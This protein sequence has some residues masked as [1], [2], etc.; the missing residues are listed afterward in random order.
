MKFPVY[1]NLVVFG[2]SKEENKIGL[3]EEKDS[4]TFSLL[5]AKLGKDEGSGDVL[6]GLI[7]KYI[8]IPKP[9]LAYAGFADAPNRYENAEQDI[10]LVYKTMIPLATKLHDGMKWVSPEDV[11]DKRELFLKD[12]YNIL[13]MALSSG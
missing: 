9:F 13:D 3:I 12:H 10:V 1:V 11:Y 5:E 6:T 7:N 8:K 4:D 2:S